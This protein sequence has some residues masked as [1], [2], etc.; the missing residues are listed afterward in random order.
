MQ[1]SF[2]AAVTAMDPSLQVTNA[3][4]QTDP[5]GSWTSKSGV[6]TDAIENADHGQQTYAF[7][8][9]EFDWCVWVFPLRF[10]LTHLALS[11]ERGPVAYLSMQLRADL[12]HSVYFRPVELP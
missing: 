6:Q 1:T 2:M 7:W 10:A 9:A 12:R 8:H 3:E 5:D 4:A 11:F